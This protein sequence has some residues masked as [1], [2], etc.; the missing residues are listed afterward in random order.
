MVAGV[1]RAAG[2]EREDLQELHEWIGLLRLLGAI[3]RHSSQ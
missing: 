2:R 3:G 1:R